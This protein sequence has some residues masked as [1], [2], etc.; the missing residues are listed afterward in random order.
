LPLEVRL[1]AGN[2][3]ER[4]YLLPLVDAV[5]ERG[6]HPDQVWA[7]RGYD[8]RALSEALVARK[9][10]PHISRRRRAGEPIPE[11]MR[12][13]DVWRG[14]KRSPKALDPE[15]PK[16]WPVERTNAWMK[17]KRRI[18]TRKDRKASTYLAFLHLAMIL[19]LARL[20]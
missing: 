4:G 9:I 16:R 1:S 19:I 3:N 18:A 20:F 5:C 14:K 8:S 13:R 6:M 11:G 10:E 17:S 7:D 15:A 12:G 2:E